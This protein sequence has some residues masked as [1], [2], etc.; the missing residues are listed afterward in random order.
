M[1][2]ERIILVGGEDAGGADA[3]GRC[4]A[5]PEVDGVG[6]IECALGADGCYGGGAPAE[7]SGSGTGGGGTASGGC[8]LPVGA[9]AGRMR[10]RVC[11]EP[12][13]FSGYA[14]EGAIASIVAA[15][16]ALMQVG[17]RALTVQLAADSGVEESV[18][19]QAAHEVLQ[20]VRFESQRTGVAVGIE[21]GVG[22]S[23]ASTG[24]L[25]RI[26]DDAAS[27]SV[28]ACLRID[29]GRELLQQLGALQRLAGR[30]HVV[31]VAGGADGGAD[32]AALLKEVAAGLEAA[33]FDR[34][35]VLPGALVRYASRLR[36]S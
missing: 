22:A 6:G 4:G 36:G 26:I 9:L 29:L 35:V 15:G 17:G 8:S 34:V 10:V 30:V 16:D 1:V 24:E 33:R 21:C 14:G 32:G 11:G 13:A 25:A 31:R 7:V 19:L 23:S 18:C 20:A 3:G 2:D 5:V 28:G 12:A 27:W